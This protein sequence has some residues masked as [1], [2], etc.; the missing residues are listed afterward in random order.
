[1]NFCAFKLLFLVTKRIIIQKT[2]KKDGISSGVVLKQ[3]NLSDRQTWYCQLDHERMLQAE[4]RE[5]NVHISPDAV[6]ENL[7]HYIE[8]AGAAQNAANAELGEQSD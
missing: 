5:V 6:I 1:M 4:D 2:I 8:N 3:E 7:P